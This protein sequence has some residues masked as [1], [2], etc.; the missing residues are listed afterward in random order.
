MKPGDAI[1]P[2]GEPYA[3]VFET[4]TSVI[5]LIGDRAYKTKKPVRLPFVDL[6]TRDRR[7]EVCVQEV[8]LNRRTAPDVYL[9]V[10]QLHD[11]IG[12]TGVENEPVVVMRR[13][14]A[15]RCL[16]V[17]LA[18]PAQYARA[19]RCVEDVA[20]R[21]ARFHAALPGITDV[22]LPGEMA[23]LWRDGMEQTEIFAGD[24]LEPAARDE[25]YALAESY[26]R[27]RSDMLADRER[28]G[29]V[30]DGHGDLLVDDV[31]LLDDG[32][33]VLDCLEFDAALRIGDVLL[34][35]AFLMMDLDLHGA[36]ELARVL[37]NR[38]RQLDAERHA[39]SLEHHY[40]AYRAWVRAKVEC[41]KYQAGDTSARER[42][43]AA[44]ALC[45]ARSR[46]AR[47]H[48]VPVGG[49][50]GSGKSTLARVLVEADDE[51]DWVLLSSDD[52]R[53]ELAGLA[54]TD[55]AAAAYGEGIYDAEHTD[56][57]YAE[58][59]RRAGRALA[60]GL[61]VV[62]DASWTDP[63]RRAQVEDLGAHTHAVVTPVVCV[64]PPHV[65][66]ERLAARRAGP[67]ASDADEEVLR[68]MAEQVADWPTAVEVETTGPAQ[69]AA[70][71][72]LGLLDA[73]P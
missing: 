50:P 26:L 49:L 32:A 45:R 29:L 13:M 55:S 15:A 16:S 5:T 70:A 52:L 39:R 8:E 18:D 60:D 54:P 38:Y 20:Q 30:R 28:A 22:D 19:R 73:L 4:H 67:R 40:V 53:K 65:C 3:R 9:G 17:L 42:A 35:L 6:S 72:V 7:L 2:G 27:G 11:L 64:A 25:S 23:R 36:P 58:L 44:L 31:Y 69:S 63:A 37:V 41:L 1:G 33:R 34:D 12:P 10:T 21:V 59:L 66:R 71:E 62:L 46:A 24:L 56:A 47:V 61:N 14:P 51:R 43:A 68:R 57:T 48:L